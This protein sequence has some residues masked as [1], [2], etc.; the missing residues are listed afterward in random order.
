[1]WASKTWMAG[2]TPGHDGAG[3]CPGHPPLLSALLLPPAIV[4]ET[5]RKTLRDALS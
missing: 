5:A 4:L 3:A 1:V 2:T